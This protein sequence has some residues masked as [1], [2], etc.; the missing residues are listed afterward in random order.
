MAVKLRYVDLMKA[1]TGIILLNNNK[2]ERE[3]EVRLKKCLERYEF[4]FLIV[5][6]SKVLSA[7]NIAAQYLQTKD[8]E[9]HL[10]VEHLLHEKQTLSTYRD[11]FADVKAEASAVCQKW[12]I[13][14][15][16]EQKRVSKV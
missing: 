7:I 1:L 2:D 6:M 16:F 3:E 14:T 8:A 11:R 13:S 9:L 5:L 10:A 15:T 12:G 4:V